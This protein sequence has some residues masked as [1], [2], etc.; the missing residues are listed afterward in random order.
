MQTISS[1]FGLKVA[2]VAFPKIR[3]ARDQNRIQGPFF[4]PRL[5]Y[6]LRQSHLHHRSL[7]SIEL[8]LLSP[9]RIPY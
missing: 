8:E 4:V 2:Q 1:P 6:I 7:V 3:T 5:I 9:V